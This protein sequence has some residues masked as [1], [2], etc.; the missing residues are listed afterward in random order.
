MV[1]KIRFRALISSACSGGLRSILFQSACTGY[2][3]LGIRGV[4]NGMEL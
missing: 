1:I 3:R 4:P 2:V